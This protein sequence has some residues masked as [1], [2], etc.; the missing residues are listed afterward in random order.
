MRWCSTSQ[1]RRNQIRKKRRNGI[2]I[3]IIIIISRCQHGYLFLSLPPPVSIVH[4]SWEVF[5]ATSCIS[6]KLM[7]IGS[8]WSYNFCVS[9]FTGP[10]EYIDY[11]LILTSP[12]VFYMPGL[13]YLD[14]F[15]ICGRWPYSWSFVGF[16]SRTSS[17]F[18]LISLWNCYQAFSPYV[19]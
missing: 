16:A 14:I 13:S 18:F 10:Q 17:I 3:I 4:C 8:S 15:V 6:T 5:Q 11:E 9:I 7:Y 1:R 19:L 2:I 12:A